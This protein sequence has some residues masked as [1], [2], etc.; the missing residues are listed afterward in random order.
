[1]PFVMIKGIGLGLGMGAWMQSG[2]E[3]ADKDKSYPI[4]NLV[5]LKGV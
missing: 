3:I 2:L 4:Q 5:R 1:M